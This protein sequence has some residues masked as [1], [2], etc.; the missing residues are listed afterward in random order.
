MKEIFE[1]VANI[2]NYKL[3]NINVV[4]KSTSDDSYLYFYRNKEIVYVID[5]TALYK[6]TLVLD[7]KTLSEISVLVLKS[8]GL[9]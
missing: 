6:A 9:V 1:Q 4:V 8:R 5:I 2:L 7:V 3:P